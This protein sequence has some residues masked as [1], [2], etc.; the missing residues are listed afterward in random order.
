MAAARMCWRA[1]TA[2]QMKEEPEQQ[3]IKWTKRNL[4][5]SLLFCG[6]AQFV[7]LYLPSCSLVTTGDWQHI[8]PIFFFFFKRVHMNMYFQ[9]SPKMIHPANKETHYVES[10]T[11]S[12]RLVSWAAQHT[13]KRI[14]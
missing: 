6:A 3:W 11:R 10:N 2:E 8:I 12:V 1:N 13:R 5:I 14:L 4:P 9:N 7:Q